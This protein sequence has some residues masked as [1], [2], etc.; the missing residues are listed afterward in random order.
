MLFPPVN[1]GHIMN[2]RVLV[3]MSGG[4]DSSVAAALLKR[5]GYDCIGIHLRFWSDTDSSGKV[6][7]N[8]CCSVAELEDARHIAQKLDIPFYVMNVEDQFKRHVVDYFLKSYEHGITPNPCIECNKNIKFGDLLK[9]AT[10]LGADYVASGHYAKV[11]RND[12]TGKYELWAGRDKEKDQSYFLYTLTQDKLAR[13][14][15]PVGDYLKK[16]I[17]ELADEFGLSRVSEKQ[18]SQGLCFFAEGSPKNFLRRYLSCDKFKHGP[19]V[20]CNGKKIGEHKGLPLYTIGQRHG[21]GIGGIKGESDGQGWYVVSIDRK[22]NAITVGREKDILE[23]SFVCGNLSFVS[24]D[25][26]EGPVEVRIRHRGERVPSS[27]E[28][29]DGKILVRAKKPLRAVS[30]GQS[31]VFYKGG[32]LIGGGVIE[33]CIMKGH[34]E[35]EAT[36]KIARE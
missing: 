13:I 15:F 9:R 6:K 10:E 7:A 12:D 1:P 24:G 14:L 32:R 17:Y 16:E 28:M 19:I 30:A 31:A 23:E 5:Q 2:K 33:S 8:K 25:I 4:V 34:V 18:Q 21:L 20:T 35:K 22:H 29:R 26:F 3:A 27:I 36:K 11:L